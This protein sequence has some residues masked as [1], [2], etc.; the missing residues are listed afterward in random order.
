MKVNKKGFSVIQLLVVLIIIGALITVV[1]PAITKK[2][3]NTKK[4]E[5][6]SVA[7]NY[8]DEIKKNISTD[9]VQCLVN[10]EWQYISEVP[11]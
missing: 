1:V 7:K 5:F 2:I 4:K 6:I 11:D 3:N 8:L 9:D 10:D